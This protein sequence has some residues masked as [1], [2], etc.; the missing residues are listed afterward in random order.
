MANLPKIAISETTPVHGRVAAVRRS[1]RSRRSFPIYISQGITV[2]PGT[3]FPLIIC[4][5]EPS[6]PSHCAPSLC[7]TKRY[8]ERTGPFD[9]RFDR[10]D[11]HRPSLDRPRVALPLAWDVQCGGSPSRGIPSPPSPCRFRCNRVSGGEMRKK[12]QSGRKGK[13]GEKARNE[14][15]GTMPDDWLLDTWTDALSIGSQ[16]PTLPLWL[17]ENLAVPLDLES[18]YE[19][20]CRILRIA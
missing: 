3:L 11:R 18:S 19:E 15:S 7:G 12:G 1:I 14:G 10:I 8:R 16:L 9:R 4:L 5:K 6:Q 17:T 2:P 20:T 13:A